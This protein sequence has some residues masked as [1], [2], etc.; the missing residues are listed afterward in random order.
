L[1]KPYSATSHAEFLAGDISLALNASAKGVER[2]DLDN[3]PRFDG[4]HRLC[5]RTISLQNSSDVGDD[6]WLN[7]F[8]RRI[9][10]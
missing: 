10:Q 6:R 1:S 5:V 8:G 2:F 3:I 4:E 7:A 9:E